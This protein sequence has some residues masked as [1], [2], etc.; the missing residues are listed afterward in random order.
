MSPAE[1]GPQARFS[2]RLPA[3]LRPN[4][5][6]ELL[7]SK[8]LAG[9]RILDL[10]ESNPTLAGFSY[11]EERILSALADTRAM[12]YEPNPAGLVTAREAASQYY[13][14]RGHTVHPARILITASTSEAYAYLFKLLCDP[15][16]EVL[17]PRPSYPLFEFLATLES[18]AVKQYPL[19]YDGVWHVDFHAL[20]AVLSDRV[21]AI[22]L[23][24][25]NNPTGSFLKRSE[26]AQ[27]AAICAARGI[28]MISDEVFADYGFGSTPD[29]V[30]T[31]TGVSEALTF[32]M[33]GLSKVAGLP[34]LK[35]GWLV[36]AGPGAQSALDRLELIADTYLSVGTPVQLALAA[37]I[38][39]GE[40]V[41]G[42]IAERTAANLDFLRAS[43]GPD[44]PYR[45]LNVEGGW[46]ATLQVPRIRTEEQW[47][48][49]LLAE[50]DLL[51]QPGFFYDFESEAFLV[52]SLLTE[53]DTFHQGVA[54]LLAS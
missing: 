4:P 47:V 26:L 46:Y 51:V 13:S 49:G 40:E 3:D 48:L 5:I 17:V 14:V 29:R 9:A 37:L 8:R 36:A 39:A 1:A 54:R 18:V 12:A 38:E 23:V 15:G 52:L 35:C 20:Q 28:A 11:P 34:Q 53:P 30:E 19:R 32:S 24:N 22:V 33:S 10:T 50:R 6:T 25:P 42:Q 16:D 41:Q 43:L 2:R 44:S 7:Q 31:L 27:L 45:V 21:R